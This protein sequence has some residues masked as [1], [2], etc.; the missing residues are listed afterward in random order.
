[1]EKELLLQIVAQQVVILK[2]LEKLEHEVHGGMR[3][4]PIQSYVD[5]LHKEAAKI[6]HQI[7]V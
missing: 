3:S 5:E 6:I 7:R 1:M 2:R 4:A